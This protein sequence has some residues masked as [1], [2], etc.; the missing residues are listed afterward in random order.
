MKNISIFFN[1]N[2]LKGKSTK[3]IRKKVILLKKIYKS[4]PYTGTMF[5]AEF[6][7]ATR[8]KPRKYVNSKNYIICTV[9]M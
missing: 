4:E 8:R 3:K 5:N 1:T 2:Y 9:D 6:F 7:F